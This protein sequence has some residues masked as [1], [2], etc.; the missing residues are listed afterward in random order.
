MKV[1]AEVLRYA[2][3]ALA[4][5]SKDLLTLFSTEKVLTVALTKIL[6]ESLHLT[7][8]NSPGNLSCSHLHVTKV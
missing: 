4:L 7:L 5:C 3:S 1:L 2:M 8:A 6:P